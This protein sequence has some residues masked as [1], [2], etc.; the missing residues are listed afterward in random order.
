MRLYRAGF[1]ALSLLGVVLV[2][3][4]V[5]QDAPNEAPSSFEIQQFSGQWQ[6]RGV[7]VAGKFCADPV[8][9]LITIK[10]GVIEGFAFGRSPGVS[11]TYFQH[12]VSGRV[13]ATARFDLVLIREDGNLFASSSGWLGAT[14]P[15][16]LL[17]GR[18]EEGCLWR[19]SLYRVD[20]RS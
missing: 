3:C 13:D 11:G 18:G 16:G 7:S 20:S 12:N 15:I 2:A 9:L 4:T 6:A 17:E 8:D 19:L 10:D 14:R 1:F 5:E